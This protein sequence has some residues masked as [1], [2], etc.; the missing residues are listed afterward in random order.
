MNVHSPSMTYTSVLQCRYKDWE[1]LL[2][3][4]SFRV[5]GRQDTLACGVNYHLA[6]GIG[7][8]TVSLNLAVGGDLQIKI[9]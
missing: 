7:I 4:F 9:I 1:G 6:D 5:L 2:K 3:P 8:V